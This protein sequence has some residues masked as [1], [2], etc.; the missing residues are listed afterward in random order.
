MESTFRRLSAEK[1]KRIVNAALEVFTRSPFKHASTDD[2][3]SK[4]GIA[5][6]SLFQYFKNKKSLYIFLYDYAL[7]VLAKKAMDRVDSSSKD[8]FE[9][10]HRGIVVKIELLKQYPHLYEFVFQAN[11]EANP[12]LAEAVA[13]ANQEVGVEAQQH[14]YA[15]VDYTRFKDSTNIG[16]LTRMIAWCTEG[17]WN[18]WRKNQRPIE[19]MYR[20]AV[21]TLDFFKAAVY[22]EEYLQNERGKS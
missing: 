15:N 2:I 4:A 7:G 1:Q 19:E 20:E 12:E 16:A 14:M 18:E 10:I 9:L 11:E 22:R 8:F 17:I 3:A 6:G 21:E 5:K 13:R